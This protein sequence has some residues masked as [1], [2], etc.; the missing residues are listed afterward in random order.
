MASLFLQCSFVDRPYISL[1]NA[2]RMF[3]Y[4]SEI[5]SFT[6]FWESIV[7]L[8]VAGLVCRQRKYLVVHGYC[9]TADKC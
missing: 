6:H 2:I 8:G 3:R 7:S 9:G 1:V 4:F 5:A